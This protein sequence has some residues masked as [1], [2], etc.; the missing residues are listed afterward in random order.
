MNSTDLNIFEESFLRYSKLWQGIECSNDQDI[1]DFANSL[2]G[3]IVINHGPEMVYLLEYQ[4]QRYLFFSS[5]ISNI[6]GVPFKSVKSDGIKTILSLFHPFDLNSHLS[7]ILP[8]F[9]EYIKNLSDDELMNTKFAF[10]YRLQQAKTGIIS[11]FFNSS[12]F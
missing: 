12:L 4:K 11:N 1:L 8:R 6:L 9:S 3:N 2:Q 10:N 5:N 7:F